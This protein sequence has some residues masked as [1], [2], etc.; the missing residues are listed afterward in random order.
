MDI[1]L[2]GELSLILRYARDEAMRTGYYG[3]MPEHLLLGILR[4]RENDACRLLEIQGADTAR[5]KK[6]VDARI[7]RGWSVPYAEQDNISLAQEAGNAM[8]LAIARARSEGR[9]EASSLHLLRSLLRCGSAVLESVFKE[10]G[11]DVEELREC[12]AGMPESIGHDK[13]QIAQDGARLSRL[14]RGPEDAQDLP[15]TEAGSTHTF[16][17]PYQTTQSGCS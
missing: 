5:M 16:I 15:Q 4:H 13:P 2:T 7:S 8:S 14:D 17:F 12:T 9:E 10:C 1:G 3:I 6:E 11:I